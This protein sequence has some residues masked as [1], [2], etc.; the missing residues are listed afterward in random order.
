[1]RLVRSE[2]D[3]SLYPASERVLRRIASGS[4][5][6]GLIS[7]RA[8]GGLVIGTLM[9]SIV[10]GIS[11]DVHSIAQWAALAMCSAGGV[12]LIIA[13]FAG[14]I[15]LGSTMGRWIL[16]AVRRRPKR[17]RRD[18]RLVTIVGRVRALRT[19]SATDG[20]RVVFSFL[21]A[22][23]KGRGAHLHK[24][25]DFILEREREGVVLVEVAHAELIGEPRNVFGA[26]P[27]LSREVLDLVPHSHDPMDIAEATL[28]AGDL[29][30]G[31]GLLEE[32][33][34]PRGERSLGRETPLLSVLHGTSK[35]P[36]RLRR[37]AASAA[38]L[39]RVPPLAR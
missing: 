30:E 26:R 12:A 16:A 23:R 6:V 1:V 39:P 25:Q 17:Q 15:S 19:L 11:A 28:R 14:G 21:S 10:A 3:P 9:A 8:A 24:A 33:V 18:P 5:R 35:I 13:L 32:R 4:K 2:L 31:T 29:V 36:L 22:T 34:D 37:R 7:V 38:T 27:G 20:E